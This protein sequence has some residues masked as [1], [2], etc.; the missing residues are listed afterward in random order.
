LTVEA[1]E[2]RSVPSFLAPL[3]YSGASQPPIVADVNNDSIADLVS[4]TGSSQ[5]VEVFLGV[6]DGLFQA[7]KFAA[8]GGYA[9]TTRS[10]DFNG[11]GKADLVV[12]NSS[13]NLALLMGRGDGTFQAPTTLTL[14]NGQVPAGVEIGD[15]NGDGKL[16]LVTTGYTTTRLRGGGGLGLNYTYHYSVDIFL[17]DGSGSFRAGKVIS[18]S[19][20][21]GLGDF[22][23]DGKLDLL[24]ADS[25]Q[26]SFRHGNGDG[27]FHKP[28]VLSNVGGVNLIVDVNGDGRLD[29]LA[30]AHGPGAVLVSL[31]NGDGTFRAAQTFFVGSDPGQVAVGDFNGD[32]K[33]DLATAN[34]QAAFQNGNG[35][36]SILLGNGDGTFQSAL[37]VSPGVN[38]FSL[39]V[40]DF[41]H[42]G[43]DDLAVVDPNTQ[44]LAILNN[45]RAW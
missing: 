2:D 21:A 18:S 28:A 30:L 20:L 32:G 9:T 6:G 39:A 22:D 25:G 37:S 1:L 24:T 26:V 11:D 34:P 7:G 31:G 29:I 27:T 36:V 23:N 14:P 15:L 45:D 43:F 12:V 38:A 5:G 8:T 4:A 19:T 16:D 40:A 41:N 44:T 35:L 42:D 10:G 17:G 33:L 13:R 3:N